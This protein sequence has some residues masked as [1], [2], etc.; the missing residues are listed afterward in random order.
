MLSQK[1][2]EFAVGT[3]Y[4]WKL[5]DGRGYSTNV[6]TRMCLARNAQQFI[7]GH[8]YFQTLANYDYEHDQ[9]SCIP[10]I[11]KTTSSPS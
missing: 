3:V 1:D 8:D 4:D 6:E 7:D 10:M 11:R 9:Q 2:W 5:G